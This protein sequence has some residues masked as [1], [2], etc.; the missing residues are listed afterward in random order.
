VVAMLHSI[1]NVGVQNSEPLQKEPLQK[2][3]SYTSPHTTTYC[4]RIKVGDKYISEKELVDATNFLKDKMDEYVNS[5]TAY[6]LQLTAGL[7]FFE[8]SF[9]LAIYYFAKQNCEYAVIETGCGG[10]YDASNAIEKPVYTIITNI[11]ADHLDIFGNLENIAKEKAGIIKPNVPIL[12]GEQNKRWL[13]IFRKEIKLLHCCIVTLLKE[14]DYSYLKDIKTGLDGT[15]FEYKGEKYRLQL[16]GE[17]QARNA[18]LAIECAKELL[19]TRYPIVQ[20]GLERAFYPA[21]MEVISKN[22]TIIIDGAHNEDKLQAT[23]EFLLTT[24]YS[25]LANKKYLI[26]AMAKNKDVKILSQF[27]KFFDRIYLTRFSNPFRKAMNYNDWLT[28]FA[29]SDKNRLY[30]K[31]YA[32][33]ALAEIL[34]KLKKNDLLVITGSI[35]L[36]GELREEWYDEKYIIQKRKS[37]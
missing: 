30:Y 22:P 9:C 16:V 34:P 17:H 29:K 31:H 12:T 5:L 32:K 27:S 4:E 33:D 18:A 24:H 25:L 1:L 28:K 6:S 26:L 10:R 23:I 2:A 35:F 11:G 20:K 7:N 14:I 13:D 3:G 15:S 8:F 19:D 21:R 36:A 37:T